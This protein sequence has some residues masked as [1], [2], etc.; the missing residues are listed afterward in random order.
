MARKGG[1]TEEA[2]A[3][4][5]ALVAGALRRGGSG[6]CAGET[7]S[8]RLIE[9]NLRKGQPGHA[10]GTVAEWPVTWIDRCVL[11]GTAIADEL[12]APAPDARNYPMAFRRLE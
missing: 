4:R 12:H 6:D 2:S 11:D 7:P 8:E 5:K 9:K 1:E 3:C 10:E